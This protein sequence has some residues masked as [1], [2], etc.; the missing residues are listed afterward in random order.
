MSPKYLYSCCS[1]CYLC[2]EILFVFF[3]YFKH[4]LICKCNIWL[5]LNNV[6]CHIRFFIPVWANVICV[7]RFYSYFSLLLNIC[8]SANVTS[9]CS[10]IMSVVTLVSGRLL[11]TIHLKSYRM[12]LKLEG[13][14]CML[15]ST[16]AY[17]ENWN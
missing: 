11:Q 4:F 13:E 15:K 10:W 1:S 17:S 8:W 3:H 12:E 14:D 9:G 5:F 7:V 2:S 16:K 6:F